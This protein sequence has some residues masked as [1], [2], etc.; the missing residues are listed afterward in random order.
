[1]LAM[2]SLG[3]G[4]DIM[5]LGGIAIAIGA[6]VDAAVVMI[7]NAHKKL[8]AWHQ[9]QARPPSAP[10]HLKLI[11][12]AA[13]EVGPALFFSLLVITLS[14]VPVFTLQAQEGRLFAPL[15][16]TKTWAMAAAA[17]LSVTLIPV[18]MS[19][20][21][22]GRIAP[23]TANPLNRILI[24]LYRPVIAL[25]LR[26]P[27]TTLL[28]AGCALAATIFP[29]KQLGSEFMPPMDEGDILYMPTAPPG[30][31][32]AE[33]SRILQE[34]DRELRAFPEV[35]SVFGKMGRAETATDP[36]PIGM[37]ET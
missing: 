14:F 23:E 18:L 21:I 29:L 10:E 36:A 22:R 2:R 19:A 12:D 34:M 5:S 30:M 7:E 25:V 6:M 17:G 11:G 37:A 20:F 16:Y 33:A 4:A 27:W 8:E 28:I 13:A 24:A 26:F 15:A 3:I 9:Q 1:F 35:Q 31:S 32:D